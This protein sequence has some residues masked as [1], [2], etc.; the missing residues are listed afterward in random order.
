M[1]G[2]LRNS[3]LP[4][5]TLESHTP[6]DRMDVVGFSLTYELNISNVLNMLS[7]GNIRLKADERNEGPIVVG[8]GPLTVNPKPFQAF[9]DLMVIGEAKEVLV[10]MLTRLK[11]LKGLPRLRIIEDLARIEGIHSPLF[12]KDRVKRLF[13]KDLDA[14]YHPLRPPI[15]IVDSVHNRLNIEISRGCGNGCRFCAAGFVYRPYRERCVEKL[16]E[17]IDRSVK[18]TGYEEISLLS[19]STGDYS[20]LSSLI[21]YLRQK[22]EDISVS[23]PSLK[24]GSI[25]DEEIELL[26]KGARGGFTFALEASTVG[27]RERLNKD[28][29]VDSLLRSLPL[30][31]KHGWRKVKLYFMVGF[32]WEKED[33]FLAL[34][35]LIIPF[36]RHGIEVNLSVSP[37]TPKPHTPFQWL[38]MQDE[39][40]LAEKIALVKKVVPARGIKVKVRDIKTSLIEALVSRGDE[41]LAPLFEYLHSKGVRLE[42]W[43]ECLKPEL[44][45]QWLAGQNGLGSELL[46]AKRP[47]Q[48][49]PWDFVDTGVSKLFLLNELERAEHC[50]KTRSCYE[51]CAACG[52][53]CVSPRRKQR[54]SETET[55]G[56]GCRTVD[57]SLF[58]S[59]NVNSADSSCRDRQSTIKDVIYTPFTLRYS[60]SGDARYIGHLDTVDLLL[61]ALRSAGISLKMHGKFH[62]KPRVSLSPALPAGIESTRE[63]VQIEAKGLADLDRALIERIDH[64]LPQGMRIL[65]VTKGKINPNLDESAYLLVGRG[66]SGVEGTLVKKVDDKAFYLWQGTGVKHLWLSGRFSRIMK[67]DRGRVL[68]SKTTHKEH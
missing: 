29:E 27:L 42:A 67:V 52:I 1:E 13:I 50:E 59:L 61:R 51:S 40:S 11:G 36:V 57:P 45:G 21:S 33:D 22:H 23:L 68:K 49:F 16:A 32:P 46:G 48:A 44:Y 34:K 47:D 58:C 18:E 43:G 19:L 63:F 6:L 7:L 15:P 8:G 25:S 5:Y 9:F 31:R 55:I 56:T 12:P 24:I 30:L 60:K 14:S 17:I 64:H 28:I 38:P 62:P 35:E 54:I 2:H 53:S 10:E 26:G 20:C 41:R 37:F 65:G 4:L 39:Q 66:D 3:G